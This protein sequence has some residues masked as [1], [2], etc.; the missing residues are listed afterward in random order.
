MGKKRRYDKFSFKVEVDGFVDAGFQKCSEIK[1]SMEV[2]EYREG[3]SV[4]PDKDPGLVNTEN[5]TLERGATDNLELYEWFKNVATGVGGE[6]GVDKRNLAIIQTDRNGNELK[7]WNIYN[8][9]PIE[10]SA[11]DFDATSN[12]KRIEK[13][14][15]A[16]DE[17][18]ES[19]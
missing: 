6:N 10:F 9:F 1:A 12:E 13:L 11:G 17:L 4:L 3:G 7:R 8:A 18:P 19:A 15:L 5:I 2:V 14:V 16:Y